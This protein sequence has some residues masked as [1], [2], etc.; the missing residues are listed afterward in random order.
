MRDTDLIGGFAKGLMV[1]EAFGA[2]KQK[3]SIADIARETGLDRATARRCLLTLAH[4][5]YAQ[6]DGKYFELTPKVLR[7]GHAYLSTTPL[8]NIVQPY[9]DEL[10]T[11][12]NQSTSVSVMDGH[13]IV[14]VARAAHRRVMSI[15]LSA[16]SRLPAYCSSMGR[17][18][19]ASLNVSDAEMRLTNSYLHQRT[20]FTKTDIKELLLELETIRN[21]GYAVIMEELEIGLCSIAVPLLNA[22]GKVIAAINVGVSTA[23]AATQPLQGEYLDALLDVQR[24]LKP[25]LP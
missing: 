9:L 22:D 4:L 6:Y 14:Y 13:E 8:T 20:V 3:M 7:L 23:E 11:K 19:L 16:G 12:L 5:S 25:L 21:L 10:T 15:N 2:Q 24:K 17:V 1:I 18:L